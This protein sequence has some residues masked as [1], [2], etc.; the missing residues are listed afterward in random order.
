MRCC[1]FKGDRYQFHDPSNSLFNHPPSPNRCLTYAVSKPTKSRSVICV[2]VRRRP[3][4]FSIRAIYTAH[5]CFNTL[6]C[7]KRTFRSVTIAVLCI[8]SPLAPRQSDTRFH[9]HIYNWPPKNIF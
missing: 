2:P 5:S 3:P 9:T 6:R 8:C 7:I 1:Y 4:R